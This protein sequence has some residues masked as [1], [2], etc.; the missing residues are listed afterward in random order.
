MFFTG[1]QYGLISHLRTC[2]K[3]ATYGDPARVS[4]AADVETFLK[5]QSKLTVPFIM[6]TLGNTT[7]E[8]TKHTGAAVVTEMVERLDI[9][10]CLN[11]RTDKVG[12]D[13]ADQVHQVRQD[14]WGCL[15]GWNPSRAA[16]CAEVDFGYRTK[17]MEFVGDSYY[18]DFREFIV[19]E[20]SYEL[21]ST[22]TN[23]AQGFGTENPVATEP[24]D[25]IYA[26]FNPTEVTASENPFPQARVE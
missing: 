24:L 19:W 14:L 21:R 5:G 20:F 18:D 16:E 23:C 10:V 13:A 2:L 8:D 4:S 25:K 3:G 22:I 6:C 15:L 12:K 17:L 7:V 9:Y 26:D 11:A 1:S